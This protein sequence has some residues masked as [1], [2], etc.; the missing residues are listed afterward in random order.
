MDQGRV[1]SIPLTTCR[2][3]KEPDL[4]YMTYIPQE[5]IDHDTHEP[6][7]I[8]V[9]IPPSGCIYKA[10]SHVWG[11]I[12]NVP[13]VC[14]SCSATSTIPLKSSET[15]RTIMAF[16]GP[17]ATV[18]MDNISIKQDDP[19]D[20]STQVAVMGRIYDEA[21]TVAVML[22]SQH[23]N[24]FKW[25]AE[26]TECGRFILMRRDKFE[27]DPQ[28]GPGE[29]EI[30]IMLGKAVQRFFAL[31]D[32][33]EHD[34]K[35]ANSGYWTRAWTFQEWALAHDV[36]ISME[37]SCNIASLHKVKSTIIKAAILATHYMMT[38]GGYA[39]IDTGFSR[40]TAL[41]KLDVVKR[42]FPSEVNFLAES[43]KNHEAVYFQASCP[44]FGCDQY[45][46]L[47]S[48]RKKKQNA[49]EVFMNRLTTMLNVFKGGSNRHAGFEAD[50]VCCWAS[51]CNINWDYVKEDPFNTALTKVTRALRQQGV[52]IYNFHSSATASPDTDPRF[53]FYSYTHTQSM[54]QCEDTI[55]GIPF[56]TGRM[57][58]RVHL[59]ASITK[60]KEWLPL[61]AVDSAGIHVQE[62]QDC[63]SQTTVLADLSGALKIFAPALSGAP[64]GF[65]PNPIEVIANTLAQLSAQDS[66]CH[67]AIRACVPLG[68]ESDQSFSAWTVV[69]ASAL[70]SVV[71]IFVGR[72]DLNGTLVVAGRM[73][74]GLGRQVDAILGYLTVTD[75]ICGSSLIPSSPTGQIFVVFDS[76]ARP[77][78]YNSGSINKRVLEAEVE[79]VSAFSPKRTACRQMRHTGNNNAIKVLQSSKEKFTLLSK[80]LADS[81]GEETSRTASK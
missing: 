13:V 3:C 40:D 39:G 55:P 68:P 62:I 11:K 56:L 49:E 33:I 48:H 71:S 41:E 19:A 43:E 76:M 81:L 53:L 18:W 74:T 31:I 77:G 61:Q 21:E 37:S 14:Q 42:L 36:D 47:R 6:V 72:E 26:L 4:P 69:P 73:N 30:S 25:L 27:N 65:H 75:T 8:L 32:K 64:D 12:Q 79:F 23:D 67:F 5:A 60:P 15:F 20:V 54:A 80:V 78:S 66:S 7:K 52:R 10:V 44:S 45:L 57:D 34:I 28:T 29:D 16:V 17:G 58:T 63:V 9:G 46:G 24:M 50:L 38:L 2:S 59:L 22:P 1:T 70:M 51:M 35:V